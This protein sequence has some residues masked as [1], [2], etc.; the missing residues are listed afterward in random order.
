MFARGIAENAFFPQGKT[1]NRALG[2]RAVPR[3]REDNKR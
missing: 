3:E 2:Q 1:E